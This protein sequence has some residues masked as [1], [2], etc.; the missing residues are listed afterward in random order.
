MYH[1]YPDHWK[2]LLIE[3]L[4]EDGSPWD[5]TTLGTIDVQSTLTKKNA[6]IRARVIAKSN[7]VWAA[8]GLVEAVSSLSE[9]IRIL[10]APQAG[11]P[12]KKGDTLIRLTGP[13]SEIFAL[14]RPFLNLAAYSCGIATRTA[15]LVELVSMACPRRTPRVVLTRK[16]L[17]GF[18]DLAVQSVILGGGF[19]HRLNLAAGVLIKENHIEAAGGIKKAILAVRKVAPHGL[20]IEVEVRNLKELVSALDAGAE[21]VLLDNFTGL[22]VRQALKT[23]KK[24]PKRAFVEVSGGINESNISDYAIEGVD[25]ISVGGLTHS[26]ISADLSWLVY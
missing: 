15:A 11:A 21:G 7:G 12:F 17:P 9:R 14:E 26:V 25:V 18:R 20:K 10:Q 23:V 19:P 4:K 2:R 6:R 5:W 3:G 1:D 8:H 16:T 24:H 13:V 22:E